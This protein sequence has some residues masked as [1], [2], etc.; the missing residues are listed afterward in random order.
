MS[1]TNKILVLLYFILPKEESFCCITIC[2]NSSVN[3]KHT[4]FISPG[5]GTSCTKLR[6]T[7]SAIV[8]GM[9]KIFMCVLTKRA[10]SGT[11]M[12]KKKASDV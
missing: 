11:G 6:E 5:S 10:D 4:L 2:F 9:I 7:F 1:L 3:L 12:K 8:Q